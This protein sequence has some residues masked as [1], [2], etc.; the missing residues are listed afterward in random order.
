[1][2]EYHHVK[3]EVTKRQ[4]LETD[5]HNQAEHI[6]LSPVQTK[7]NEICKPD[8]NKQN[9]DDLKSKRITLSKKNRI[10]C[11]FKI[12]YF[13][14]IKVFVPAKLSMSS[15]TFSSVFLSKKNYYFFKVHSAI[16]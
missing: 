13:A 7:V 3:D 11:V 4:K 9:I 1:M 8:Q 10:S 2:T 15:A 6:N 12:S 5:I 14:K 16:S